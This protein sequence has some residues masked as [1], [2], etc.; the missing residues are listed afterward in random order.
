MNRIF[1]FLIGIFS[2]A[3][4]GGMIALL[5]AP[6]SGASLRGRLRGRATGFFSEVRGAAELRRRELEDHLA[7]LRL[8]RSG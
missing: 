6:E 5:L 3:L 8:P 7:E 1:G 4:V 2:G